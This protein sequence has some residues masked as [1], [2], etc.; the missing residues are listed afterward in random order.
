MSQINIIRNLAAYA[1]KNTLYAITLKE[2][3]SNDP[4]K[5]QERNF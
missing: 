2:Q 3:G 1:K 5:R 4:D